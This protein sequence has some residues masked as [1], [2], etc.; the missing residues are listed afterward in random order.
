MFN[1][2]A[3]TR[4]RQFKTKINL[5]INLR[6]YQAFKE[7]AGK[8]LQPKPWVIKQMMKRLLDIISV[9]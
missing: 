2:L 8:R 4:I 7:V 9:M 6:V 1:N 3:N 5:T